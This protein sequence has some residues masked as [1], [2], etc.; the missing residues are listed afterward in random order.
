M[1]HGFDIMPLNSRW[2]ADRLS[3][4]PHV[5]RQE[6]E[7]RGPV[8]EDR[9]HPAAVRNAGKDQDIRNAI[10]QIVQDFATPARFAG[11]EGDHAVEHVAPEAQIAETGREKQEDW[12]LA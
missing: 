3:K 8:A 1:R 5:R 7:D 2:T 11:S 4:H 10:R 9:I 6:R 12:M